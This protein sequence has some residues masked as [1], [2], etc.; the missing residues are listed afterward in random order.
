[1]LSRMREPRSS[2]MEEGFY[3]KGLLD[4]RGLGCYP[5][6]VRDPAIRIILHPRDTNPHGSIF[7]GVILS[8]IDLAGEVEARKHGPRT[9]VT[10]LMRQVEFKSPV[11]MGDIVSFY[12]ET[13]KLGRTSVTIKVTVEAER[14]GPPRETVQ[15]TEAELVFVAVDENHRPLPIK[16]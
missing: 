3:R 7:G 8:H 13:L 15:V 14:K 11:Y 16:G 10:V 6:A 5:V 2:A 4:N 12:T 9:Y 1:M